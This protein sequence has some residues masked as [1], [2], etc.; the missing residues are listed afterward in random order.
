MGCD[1]GACTPVKNQHQC[2]SCWAFGG[3]E[4]LES[5]YKITYGQLN[6]LSPEQPTS[7][8]SNCG[9][10]AGGNA[11]Y[12]WQYVNSVGGQVSE[13][14]YPYI[15]GVNSTCTSQSCT[16]KCKSFK[17]SQEPENI[18]DDIGYWVSNSNGK[19]GS[20]ADMLKAIQEH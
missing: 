8:D 2:G 9:G 14:D 16:P 11:I 5:E 12:A 6:V 13:S 10:C 19:V 15:A 20:E 7:C 18:G 3:T 1:E 4:C 17:K